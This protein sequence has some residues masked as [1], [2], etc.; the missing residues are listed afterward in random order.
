MPSSGSARPC[1]LT[2]TARFPRAVSVAPPGSV[3]A[4][5]PTLTPSVS[6][7]DACTRYSKS[8]T[9]PR[10]APAYDINRVREPTVRPRRGLPVTASGSSNVT[11]A[12]IVSPRPYVSPLAGRVVNDTRA[13]SEPTSAT[14]TT[15]VSVAVCPALSVTVS[16]NAIAVVARRLRGAVKVARAVSAP[17]SST[18]GAPLTCA[19]RYSKLPPSS[20]PEPDSVTSAPSDT[21][22]C[23]PPAVTRGGS[24]SARTVIRTVSDFRVVTVRPPEVRECVTRSR[25]TRLPF[26]VNSG[27]VNVGVAVDAPRSDTA[28]PDTRLQIIAPFPEPLRRTADP[29]STVWSG[30]AAAHALGGGGSGG[31]VGHVVLGPGVQLLPPSPPPPPPPPGLLGHVTLG[32]G[33]QLL[34]PPPPPPPPPGFVGGV[35]PPPPACATSETASAAAS[36]PSRAAPEITAMARKSR[37]AAGACQIEKTCGTPRS[38]KTYGKPSRP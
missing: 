5:A 36:A 23:P 33:V 16:R 12:P 13:A 1:R 27:A 10:P 15:V 34:P 11:R 21:R 35:P 20:V 17:D 18:S 37:L 30:P 9:R 38:P 32:P 22:R 6:R 28:G 29:S 31:R 8:S 25:N 26:D 7:S 19:Q 24:S 14:V 3:S 4:P 2:R